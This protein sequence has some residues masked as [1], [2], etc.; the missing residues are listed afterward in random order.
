[1]STGQWYQGLGLGTVW[2][3][4]QSGVKWGILGGDRMSPNPDHDGDGANV[5]TGWRSR[6][7]SIERMAIACERRCSLNTVQFSDAV[8][9]LCSLY[10]LLKC[11]P[12]GWLHMGTLISAA[13]SKSKSISRYKSFQ[14]FKA[15][16]L[17][18][19]GKGDITLYGD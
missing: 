15:A 12:S 6:V 10:K 5:Y 16:Y 13:S 17:H 18:K 9:F 4:G 14:D 19:F 2:P 8:H 11:R 3:V 7:S 1:M